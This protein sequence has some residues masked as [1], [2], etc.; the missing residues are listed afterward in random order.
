MYWGVRLHICIK[1]RT[2]NKG[3]ILCNTKGQ[4]QVTTTDIDKK[5][6][7]LTVLYY[8]YYILYYT[9]IKRYINQL[10]FGSFHVNLSLANKC[11]MEIFLAL[12]YTH[13]EK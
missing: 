11:R 9:N 10:E 4:W 1:W 8:A 3:G 2:P 13:I 6:L 5:K 12:I 7:I